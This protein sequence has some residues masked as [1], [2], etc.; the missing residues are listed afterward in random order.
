MNN[1][2]Y[3]TA[4]A[5]KNISAPAKYLLNN[6]FVSGEVLDYGCGRGMDAAVL[7]RKGFKVQQYDPYHYLYSPPIIK[8]SSYDTILCTYV[9]NVV[10][11]ETRISII[12]DVKRLLKSGGKAYFSVRRDIKEEGWTRRGTYQKNV[13]MP[14]KVIEENRKYCI[15]EVPK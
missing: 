2:S 4:I 15:Y 13:I 14:Y 5:R 12:G 11:R 8:S 6:G 1:K 10:D 3:L 7:K 9:L